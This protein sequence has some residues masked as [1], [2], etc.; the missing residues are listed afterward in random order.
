M[1]VLDTAGQEE[2]SAMREQWIRYGEGFFV[3]YSITNRSS[4]EKE[5]APL[6]TQ[7]TRVRDVESISEVPVVLFGNKTDLE[8]QR[9]IA[10]TEG[11][12]KVRKQ[13]QTVLK[14]SFLAVHRL[15]NLELVAP[16][17]RVG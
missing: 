1:E 6:F 4:F 15:R 11:Q 12:E 7:I 3:V 13:A 2:Y 14:A 10:T 5:L 9:Q 16:F 17:P 8:S